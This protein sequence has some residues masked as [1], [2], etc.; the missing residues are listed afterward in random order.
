[1][2]D[3]DSILG[4]L[5][6]Y[7]YDGSNYHEGAVIKAQINGTPSD[8][9]DMPTEL[10]F[11]TTADGAGSPTSRMVIKPS[12]N[13]GIGTTA[14]SSML[15]LYTTTNT[16]KLTIESTEAGASTNGFGINLYRNSASP[17]TNDVMSNIR[18]IGRND[19]TQDVTYAQMYGQISS[20]SDGSENGAYVIQTMAGGS[21][22]A[23]ITIAPS[24]TQAILRSN[25]NEMQH[26]GGYF[27]HY[28]GYLVLTNTLDLELY[29]GDSQCGFLFAGIGH[30]G[31]SSVR[32]KRIA[33][34]QQAGSGTGTWNQNQILDENISGAGA[35]TFSEGSSGVQYLR[36][37]KSAGT[38]GSGAY[39]NIWYIGGRH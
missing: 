33:L 36:I 14:P 35:W 12:G 28:E 9:T 11:S 37:Q 4:G 7:G 26:G 39:Y 22:S 27:Y 23:A 24:G 25:A 6:F 38:N 29:V 21:L 34:V 19:N 3:D 30:N 2:V 32:A 16:E 1:M 18:F 17:A 13:V 5:S 20:A 15:H 10:V 31:M 8:G